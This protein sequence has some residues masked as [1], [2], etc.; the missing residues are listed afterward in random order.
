MKRITFLLSLCLL[1]FVSLQSF[2]QSKSILFLGNSYTYYNGGLPVMLKDVANSMGE[3]LEVESNAPGGYTLQAHSTNVTS[4]DLIASRDWDYVV[5]QEQSQRPSFPPSQVEV[6][7]YPYATI[8]CDSISN[9]SSCTQTLFFMTWGY[10]NGDATNCPYYTPL[11]SYLGMQWRLR[12]SYVEMAENNDTW[13]VPCGMAVKAVR[14]SNP[15]IVLYSGD[16][17]HPSIHGTYLAACTFFSS[18]YHRSPVGAYIPTEI[19]ADEAAI[20]QNAAWAVVTDT[21]EV[22]RIDT[23][24]VNSDFAILYLTKNVTSYFDNSSINAD[25]CVWDYGDGQSQVQY[26]ND[27]YFQMMT[28][29]YPEVGDYNVCLTAYKDCT[30]E[31][32]C[33]ICEV[34]ISD[35]PTNS[36]NEFAIFPNPVATDVINIENAPKSVCRI[37]DVQGKVVM[38]TKIIDNKINI[39]ELCAGSYILQCGEVSLKFVIE[40]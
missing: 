7:V 8:L 16:G 3:V 37:I 32:T 2:S 30:F 6:E 4:L 39:S 12:Q 17:S 25:S 27:G 10:E 21:L 31:K 38:K 34:I 19:S 20:L 24:T 9:N 13:A 28:H 35:I 22:W 23:T 1:S 14:E 36:N 5:L 29:D 33:K 15:E 40:K 26:P 18:I 11:C